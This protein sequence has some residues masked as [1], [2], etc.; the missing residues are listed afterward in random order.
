LRIPITEKNIKNKLNLPNILRGKIEKIR[1]DNTSGSTELAKQAAEIFIFLVDN[2][3]VTNSSKLFSL[4][5]ETAYELIKAQPTMASI[6]NLANTTLIE[7]IDF[8]N[9]NEIKQNIREYCKQFI[10]N[11]ELSSKIISKLTVNIIKDDITIITHSYSSTLLNTLI[12]AKEAGRKINIICTESRPMNEGIKLAKQLGKK[13]IDVKLMVDTAVYSFLPD[14][15]LILVGADAVSSSGIIN[16]VGTLGL[17]VAAKQYNKKVYVLCSMDKILP[18]EY[19]I[20]F[21]YQKNPKEIISKSIKNVTP[22]NYYFDL[23]PFEFIKGI[24]T[25]KGILSPIELQEHINKIPIHR[26]LIS[27]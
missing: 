14:S 17:A 21:K 26:N 23:T 6:V 24:I 15:D 18:K 19:P 2:V 13:G 12:F 25:E 8:K 4:I 20:I 11:L 5:Q 3:S 1:L 9:I 22:V 10:Q 16:K 7:N 27:K